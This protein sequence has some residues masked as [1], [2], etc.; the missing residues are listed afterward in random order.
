MDSNESQRGRE[1]MSG[2]IFERECTDHSKTLIDELLQTFFYRFQGLVGVHSF[3]PD[4]YLGSF[5]D[6]RRH[7]VHD[8]DR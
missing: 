2:Q 4:R 6:V 5:A 3:C 8:A 1:R 7:N